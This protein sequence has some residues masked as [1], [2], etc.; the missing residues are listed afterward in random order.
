MKRTRKL[1]H[2][3]AS[4]RR[5]FTLIELL[6]VVAIIAILAA[7]LLPALSR[8]RTEARKSLAMNNLSQIGRGYMMVADDN[9]GFL[10]YRRQVHPIMGDIPGLETAGYSWNLIS[11]KAYSKVMVYNRSRN[12]IPPLEAAREYGFNTATKHPLLD[13][14][15]TWEEDYAAVTSGAVYSFSVGIMCGLGEENGLNG[16]TN[17]TRTPPRKLNRGRSDDTIVQDD[18]KTYLVPGSGNYNQYRTPYPTT[19]TGLR[20]PQFGYYES[21]TD[22]TM[23][24][25]LTRGAY[26]CRYDGSVTWTDGMSLVWKRYGWLGGSYWGIYA[27]PPP[28]DNW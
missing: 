15:R 6:V 20:D 11:F 25:R 10:P 2:T 26:A 14:A 16:S 17:F 9:D 27:M 1:R 28:A 18:V 12:I 8:A 4:A 3:G 19:Q 21:N 7:M 24:G 23:L 5:E 22:E 13:G